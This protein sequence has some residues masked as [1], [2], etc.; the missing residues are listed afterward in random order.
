MD[1]D[2]PFLDIEDEQLNEVA[3]NAQHTF[4][5]S[6][7]RPKYITKGFLKNLP[8]NEEEIEEPKNRMQ[9]IGFRHYSEPHTTYNFLA[10]ATA[11]NLRAKRQQRRSPIPQL[12]ELPVELITEVF[13]HLH[14]IDL[15][16]L[17]LANGTLRDLV[18]SPSALPLWK[19]VWDRHPSVAPCPPDVAYPRWASLI[20]GPAVCDEC[21]L[22]IALPNFTYRKRYCNT[23][24]YARVEQ[25]TLPA[26]VRPLIAGSFWTNDYVRYTDQDSYYGVSYHQVD[27]EP[28]LKQ[29]NQLEADVSKNLPGSEEKMAAFVLA[30]QTRADAVRALAQKGNAW[31]SETYKAFSA[32][33][34]AKLSYFIGRMRRSVL[35]MGFAEADLG[36]FDSGVKRLWAHNP[37]ARL[38]WRYA[39]R[40]RGRILGVADQ[41][42]K[43]KIAADQLK[44]QESCKEVFR[45][46][47]RDYRREVKPVMWY[48]LPSDDE[49]FDL[50]RWFIHE[51]SKEDKPVDLSECRYAFESETEKIATWFDRRREALLSSPSLTDPDSPLPPMEQMALATSI[52]A[53]G[54]CRTFNDP[55]ISSGQSSGAALFGWDDVALHSNCSRLYEERA[56]RNISPSIPARGFVQHVLQKLNLDPNT[57]LASTLDE[58]NLWFICEN[59]VSWKYIKTFTWREYVR[60]IVRSDIY[61]GAQN[62][63]ADYRILTPEAAFYVQLRREADP[64]KK[65]STWS[66]NHCPEHLDA[67]VVHATAVQH[68]KEAHGIQRPIL[69]IDFIHYPLFV[70]SPMKPGPLPH[71]PGNHQCLACPS[72][73][74]RHMYNLPSVKMHLKDKHQISSPVEGE[75]W[76]VVPLLLPQ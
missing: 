15:Y 65:D 30:S 23:C 49:V 45:G 26:P 41:S 1:F 42:R 2:F 70:R 57:T 22:S 73:M 33:Q 19:I 12:L 53:C 18:A 37:N 67:L 38:S 13:G 56:Y 54:A 35:K 6:G 71:E 66:C 11:I 47:Y 43:H 24:F 7:L 34:D 9:R 62:P 17:T 69:G 60:H 76:R 72:P 4:S 52:F 61:H 8:F 68:V 46:V 16:H 14:P 31:F 5:D 20:F 55:S 25:T 32:R 36:D 29:Y 44:R 74:P 64:A 59:C 48:T 39:K 51:S 40:M 27:V 3:P 21:N 63:E 28:I 10:V 75:H 58:Q 50:C